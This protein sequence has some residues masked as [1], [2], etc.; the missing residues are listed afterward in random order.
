MRILCTDLEN[1]VFDNFGNGRPQLNVAVVFRAN[2]GTYLNI[3]LIQFI[4]L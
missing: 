3:L 1:F 2:D 4:C